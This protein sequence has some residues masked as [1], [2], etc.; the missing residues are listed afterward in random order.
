MLRDGTSATQAPSKN[1]IFSE[2][3]SHNIN[4][5][6]QQWTQIIQFSA[7]AMMKRKFKDEVIIL[8]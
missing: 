2:T 6:V 8:I 5:I 3:A 1:T 4:K 7:N